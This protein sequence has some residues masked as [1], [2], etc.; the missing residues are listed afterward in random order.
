M[1][2]H[3]NQGSAN[4]PKLTWRTNLS[5]WFILILILKSETLGCS[6]AEWLMKKWT[7]LCLIIRPQPRPRAKS[8]SSCLQGPA[9]RRDLWHWWNLPCSKLAATENGWLTWRR[10]IERDKWREIKIF[11]YRGKT[12]FSEIGFFALN[13][14]FEMFIVNFCCCCC[15]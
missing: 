5:I 14:N 9:L 2:A 4:S 12:S 6:F 13:L 3:G 7:L 15:C 8:T 11:F 1:E 10:E